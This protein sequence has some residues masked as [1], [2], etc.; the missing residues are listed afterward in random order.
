MKF[1]RRLINCPHAWGIWR[2]AF[3]CTAVVAILLVGCSNSGADLSAVSGRVT[4]DGEPLA[5]ARLRFQPEAAD[6]SPSYGS[7]DQEGRYQLSFKRGQKGALIGWHT[8]RIEAGAAPTGAEDK[9]TSRP[10][11]LPAR[12]SDSSELREEVKADED[13]E[14]DFALTSDG[15]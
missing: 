8:V 6:G 10:K 14:I 9:A 4:L 5:G 12:Y 7:T 11:R 1:Q 15:K 13:N 2:R 3:P